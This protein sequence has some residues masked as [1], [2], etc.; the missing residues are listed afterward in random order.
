MIESWKQSVLVAVVLIASIAI[1][2]ALQ[3]W[4]LAHAPADAAA[5]VLVRNDSGAVLVV[6]TPQAAL[7]YA[8]SLAGFTVTAPAYLPPGYALAEIDIH[9]HP[10][11]L[12]IVCYRIVGGRAPAGVR[13]SPHMQPLD[14][15]CPI[16][17]EQGSFGMVVVPTHPIDPIGETIGSPYAHPVIE[18]VDDYGY[19]LIT[20][21]RTL[22]VEMASPPPLTQSQSIRILRSV[23]LD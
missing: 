2:G 20:P 1:G 7:A 13:V 23:P 15:R 21:T 19:Y 22:G 17:S 18:K 12:P 14:E 5:S 11:W 9:L 16:L 3:A 4:S 6:S 10:G 8:S